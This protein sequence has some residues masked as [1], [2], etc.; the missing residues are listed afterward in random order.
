MKQQEP[1][2][3][4]QPSAMRH[5]GRPGVALAAI[6]VMAGCAAQM[7]P[8]PRRT[9]GEAGAP[10]LI[11]VGDY[12]DIRF[13]KTPELNVEVPV[14]SDGKISLELLGD[15]QAAGQP[16]EELAR[17]LTQR[18]ASEL[19]NPRVSVIVRVFGGDVFVGGE[20]KTPSAPPFAT[21][22]TALQAINRAGGFLDT[23]KTDSVILIRREGDH[24]QGYRLA[25][26][27]VLSGT[28]LSADVPL[29]PS[30]IIHVPKT[31]IAN[32]DVFVDQYVRKVLPVS[33]AIGA[34][35]F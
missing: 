16:P 22:M 27:K 7:P 4:Q 30:D 33:P 3:Y 12:L 34:G 6:L 1:P 18:Y 20:V 29:Q 9:V 2:H 26:N 15:V 23:A 5:S 8:P 14:R 13:Y 19:T 31:R 21:G 35:V 25:M 28:D 32:V 24:Y 17:T 11:K 10:Y